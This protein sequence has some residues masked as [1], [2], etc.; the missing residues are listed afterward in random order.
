MY[1]SSPIYPLQSCLFSHYAA[2]VAET[3]LVCC[4]EPQIMFIIK[5]EQAE[6]WRE[7]KDVEQ[8]IQNGKPS[9]PLLAAHT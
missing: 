3:S 4:E 2:L 9:L 5:V 6:K 7:V 1:F 8:Q